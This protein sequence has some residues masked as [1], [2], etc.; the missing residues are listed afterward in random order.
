MASNAPLSTPISI[1][2]SRKSANRSWGAPPRHHDDLL[3][4]GDD[5]HQQERLGQQPPF[6]EGL[7]HRPEQLDE[8]EHQQQDAQQCGRGEDRRAIVEQVDER[9]HRGPTSRGAPTTR[10]TATA[11]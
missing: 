10:I 2:P 7:A 3:D 5:A 6:L 11:K 8:D 9:G 4:R 1:M